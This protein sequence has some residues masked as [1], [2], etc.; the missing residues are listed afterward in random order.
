MATSA[1][2]WKRLLC[3]L[4]GHRELTNGPTYSSTLPDGRVRN[5]RYCLACDSPVWDEH[6]RKDET[7]TMHHECRNP[8]SSVISRFSP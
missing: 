2:L 1:W 7:P 8:Q 5:L 4:H 3:M 6:P